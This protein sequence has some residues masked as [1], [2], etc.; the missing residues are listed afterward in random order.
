[1]QQSKDIPKKF[2][3]EAVVYHRSILGYLKIERDAVGIFLNQ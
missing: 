2:V 1:M 3:V